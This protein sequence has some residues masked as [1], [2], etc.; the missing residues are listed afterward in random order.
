MAQPRLGG[1]PLVFG[2][3]KL[4]RR[5]FEVEAG[6]EMAAP[7][8]QQDGPDGRVGPESAEGI[9]DR[10]KHVAVH[11]VELVGTGELDMGDPVRDPDL[12]ALLAHLRSPRLPGL[13]LSGNGG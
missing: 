8:R 13:Y 6:R 10:A 9:A 2:R 5:I 11:G 4:A 7:A 3:R 1:T 12:D